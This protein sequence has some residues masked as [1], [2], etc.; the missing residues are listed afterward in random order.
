M[1]P[2]CGRPGPGNSL[3]A[4]LWVGL[5]C[6][7]EGWAVGRGSQALPFLRSHHTA[8]LSKPFFSE[9]LCLALAGGGLSCGFTSGAAVVAGPTHSSPYPGSPAGWSWLPVVRLAAGQAPGRDVGEGKRPQHPP[10]PAS[11]PES[12]GVWHPQASLTSSCPAQ[13]GQLCGASW[14]HPAGPALVFTFHW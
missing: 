11:L 9:S 3:L 2:R 13:F 5:S 4:F 12:F 7:G 6:R 10:S 8:L 1:K 14:C